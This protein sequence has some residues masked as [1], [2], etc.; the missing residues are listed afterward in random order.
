MACL[1]ICIIVAFLFIKR[2]KVT[3][4]SENLSNQ[5]AEP[6]YEDIQDVQ[7]DE[8]R[9][10][11]NVCYQQISNSNTSTDS[12]DPEYTEVKHTK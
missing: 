5:T 4:H 8:L 9:T 10:E 12:I 6:V 3:F 11:P 1:I 7:R 2:K